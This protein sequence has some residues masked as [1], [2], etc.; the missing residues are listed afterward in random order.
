V[1]VRRIALPLALG[2]LAAAVAAGFALAARPYAASSGLHGTVTRGPLTPV[3]RNDVPCEV[4]VPN[5]ELSFDKPDVAGFAARRV[6]TD[7]DGNYRILLPAGIYTV[8]MPGRPRFGKA[9][10]PHQVKVR[11]AH[12]DRLDFHIDTGIR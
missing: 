9:S 1:N 7:E 4:P 12:V 3:C 8:T 11:L 5:L 2:G 10:S 6:E